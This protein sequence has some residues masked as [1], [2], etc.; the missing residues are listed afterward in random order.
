AVLELSHED[1]IFIA[2]LAGGDYSD[3]L[4]QCGL[5][6]AIGLTRAGLGRQLISGVCG[7][8]RASAL[9]FLE[10]WRDSLRMELRTNASGH[11]PHR[12]MQ[13][14]ADMASNFPDLEVINLYCHPVLSDA[15]TVAKS[16]VLRPPRLDIL[17]CFAEDHFTW[18]DSIGILEHFSDQLFAGL[19]VR[20]LVRR[21]LAVDGLAS[22]LETPSI[23]KSIVGDRRH[24][25]TGYLA[26]LCLM[27]NLD[28]IILTEALQA[29][30]GR[31]N[32]SPPETEAAVMKWITTTLPKVRVWAP[33]S[34]VEYV[35]P[36]LVL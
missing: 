18:G 32:A 5:K 8:T 29:I 12:C 30:T 28:P 19:V 14:A 23:I 17:A 1:L 22:P 21:A 16:L 35:Y 25:S 2:V 34:V 7:Q 27:L 33:R 13:L 26:E 10:I 9:L 15:T 6:I 4:A 24:R 31:H 20:D 3:G 36:A 11:L